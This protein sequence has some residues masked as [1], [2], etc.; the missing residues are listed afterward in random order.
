MKRFHLHKIRITSSMNDIESK[1]AHMEEDPNGKWV[2]YED[3]YD[4]IGEKCDCCGRYGHDRRTLHMACG[5][6][7]SELG[8]PFTMCDVPAIPGFN[9]RQTYTLRC[10]KE[11]RGGWMDAIKEWFNHGEDDD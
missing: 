6:D 9:K 8:L 2:Q 5:Y 3:V 11:C 7:M 1:S 10:C 4:E